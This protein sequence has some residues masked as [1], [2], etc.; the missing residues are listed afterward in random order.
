M[1]FRNYMEDVVR[2]VYQEIIRKNPQFCTCDRCRVDTMLIALRHL[3]GMYA[4]S[5]EGEIFTK[6]SRD[7]RQIRAD[8][9]IILLQAAEQVSKN[10]NH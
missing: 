1:N 6:L 10:P 4:V 9:L 2:E 7:D 5:M 8:A 3:K